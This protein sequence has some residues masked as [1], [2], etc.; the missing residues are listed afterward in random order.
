ML[1]SGKMLKKTTLYKNIY[2]H[3]CNLPWAI[4]MHSD[5]HLIKMSETIRP[6]LSAH[7]SRDSVFPLKNNWNYLFKNELH[8][9]TS[10]MKKTFCK[11][12]IIDVIISFTKRLNNY[13]LA[14]FRKS[15]TT[16]WCR[17]NAR[18]IDWSITVLLKMMTT[19][20]QHVDAGEI[21]DV[22]KNSC[23]SLSI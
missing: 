7:S 17:P 8:P 23:T 18:K 12:I 2:S 6:L 22:I 5:W 11:C 19:Y 15:F 4:N 14:S 10:R 9:M 20:Q 3:D 13:D 16:K 21:V 1:S